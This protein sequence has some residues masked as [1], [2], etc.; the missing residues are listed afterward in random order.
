[1]VLAIWVALVDFLPMI[2]GLLAGVPTVI[3]ASLHSLPAGI[4]TLIVFLIYQQ[5]ENHILNPVIMSRTVK[6]KALY[7]LLAVLLGAEIGYLVGSLFGGLVG[8][9]LSVPA[10]S[11]IQV[12][13]R[14]LLA[15]RTGASLLGIGP[16]GG[17][18]PIPKIDL[19]AAVVPVSSAGKR[20]GPRPRRSYGTGRGRSPSRPP[21]RY[22]SI[23][24][25]NVGD[26]VGRLFGRRGD[27]DDE[28]RSN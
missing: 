8:A 4:V 12:I 28:G 22:P 20:D 5:I 15:H 23:G 9:L 16:E 6:L 2:G 19:S 24:S 3:I 11:A 18:A 25:F 27:P 13:A 21:P 1:M 10:A 26:W 14:D 7:V 17:T